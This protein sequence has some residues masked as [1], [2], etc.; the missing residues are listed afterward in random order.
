M[1]EAR[2]EPAIARAP[3][4]CEASVLIATRDRCGSLA[5][6]LGSLAKQRGA[7]IDWEVVVVDNGSIDETRRVIDSFAG[8]LPL[9][10]IEEPVPG[11]NR[12]LNRALECARGQLVLFTDD[13][14]V[15]PPDWVV[16]YVEAS[17]RWKEGNVF[18]GPIE[19]IFPETTPGWLR[20][21]TFA[22]ASAAYGARPTLPEGATDVMPFGANF[23]VRAAVF[24]RHRFE[25]LVG[26]DGTA[27]YRQGSE[28]EFL[29]RLRRSGER[30]IHVPDA[31]VGHVIAAH[32]LEI[33]WLLGRVE[34]IARGSAR[35]KGK[36]VPKT[37][38]GWIPLYVR[39][40]TS[41]W[42]ALRARGLPDEQRF[43]RSERAHY[44]RGYVAEAR[45]LRAELRSARRWLDEGRSR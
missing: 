18:G 43:E 20:S 27:R 29:L 37:L 33:D 4:P 30:F 12:A 19:P 23:A 26:P 14:V 2:T 39:L 28:H 31:R 45:M 17:H 1:R 38:V 15:L 24:E 40:W 41:E 21:P 6:T 8:R 34:R 36:R 35:I 16:R 44:W 13:D 3:R 11:K 5:R 7:G 32:Q 22:L 10:T 42:R 25:E 9:R